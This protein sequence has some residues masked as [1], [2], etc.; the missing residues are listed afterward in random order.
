M[1]DRAS[2]EEN[3]GT[4]TEKGHTFKVCPFMCLFLPPFYSKL[5]ELRYEM[6]SFARAMKSLAWAS[7]SFLPR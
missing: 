4:K 7:V 5:Y 3:A 2:A 6:I 1:D